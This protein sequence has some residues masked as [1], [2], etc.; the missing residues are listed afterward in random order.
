MIAPQISVRWEGFQK[1]RKTVRDLKLWDDTALRTT[2]KVMQIATTITMAIKHRVMVRGIDSK[3]SKYK[4]YNR[5]NRV[6]VPPWYPQ[7]R[8]PDRWR[9]HTRL[10]A[11]AWYPSRAAYQKARRLPPHKNFFASGGMWKGLTAKALAPGHVRVQFAGS[12]PRMRATKSFFERQRKAKA[13]EKKIPKMQKMQNRAKASGSARNSGKDLLAFNVEEAKLYLDLMEK[14][15]DS[16]CLIDLNEQRRGFE[17]TKFTREL[18]TKRK[19]YRA[20]ARRLMAKA[21]PGTGKPD[22]KLS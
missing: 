15:I 2:Q 22:P 18:E 14:L 19:K 9:A 3:G 17:M 6:A 7:P 12:S 13:E 21:A 11:Y 5:T 8:A 20:K 4:A 16:H 1:D 10:N